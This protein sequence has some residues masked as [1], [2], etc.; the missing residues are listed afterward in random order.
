MALK[1]VD[2]PS[3]LGPMMAVIFPL[4]IDFDHAVA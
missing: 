2:F 4:Y 1:K 3:P